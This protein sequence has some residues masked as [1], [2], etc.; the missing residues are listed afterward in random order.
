[1][2]ATRKQSAPKR[3]DEQKTRHRA[4]RERFQ[5]ERPSLEQLLA[6]GDYEDPVSLEQYLSLRHAL[7]KLKE[8]RE[9]AGVSLNEL[10][11]RSG[12][13]KAALSRL[14]NGRQA[15]PTIDTL[16]RYAAA[17][18]MELVWAVRDRSAGC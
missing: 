13:D 15:N 18:D 5:R 8:H 14:E 2:C 9:R 4:V 3:T 12:I 10:A 6:T 16:S 17:L 11:A 1:M 7:H